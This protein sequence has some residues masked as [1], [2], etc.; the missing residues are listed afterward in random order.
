MQTLTFD[1]FRRRMNFSRRVIISFRSHWY[2]IIKFKIKCK[3]IFIP[4][5]CII[6]LYLRSF[7]INFCHFHHYL[8]CMQ[9]FCKFYYFCY[10]MQM[11]VLHHLYAY[12]TLCCKLIK[13]GF[14]THLPRSSYVTCSFLLT[15]SQSDVGHALTTAGT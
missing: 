12:Y 2:F 13:C 8:L 14:L 4:I 5:T 7:I 10:I 9:L 1:S 3:H 6:K 15:H 11:F